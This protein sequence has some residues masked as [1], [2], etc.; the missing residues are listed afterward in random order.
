MAFVRTKK[1]G[2]K[3]Y[4]YLVENHW[5]NGRARQTVTQYLG[6]VFEHQAATAGN[7]PDLSDHSFDEAVQ[8]L[9]THELLGL[10][11]DKKEKTLVRESVVIDT[12]NWTVRNKNKPAVLKINN[13]YLCGH[14]AKQLINFTPQEDEQ[15]TGYALARKLVEAGLA[16]PQETFVKLFEKIQP[17]EAGQ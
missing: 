3:P 1:I 11:F 4:A 8:A 10:G 15:A 9:I 17:K 5:E 2:G 7:A 13:G 16:V 14:T 6:R 12:T